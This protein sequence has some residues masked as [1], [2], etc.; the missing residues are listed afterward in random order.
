MVHA[1]G[2]QLLLGCLACWLHGCAPGGHPGPRPSWRRL[3]RPQ[4]EPPARCTADGCAPDTRARQL[5]CAGPE[6]RSTRP[7][8]AA[9]PPTPQPTTTPTPPLQVRRYEDVIA[10]SE[11]GAALSTREI[12]NSRWGAAAQPGL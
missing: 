11:E 7:A 2:R 1:G 9:W 8:S 6:G 3:A 5:A 4:L 12:R 10:L